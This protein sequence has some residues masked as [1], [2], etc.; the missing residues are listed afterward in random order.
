MVE[1]VLTEGTIEH[2]SLEIEKIPTSWKRSKS[3][4]EKRRDPL[5]NF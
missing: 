5:K 1:K 3:Y 4:Y 2:P